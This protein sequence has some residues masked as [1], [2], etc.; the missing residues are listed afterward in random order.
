MDKYA[1]RSL[2]RITYKQVLE[3]MPRI[4]R[5]WKITTADHY[6]PFDTPGKRSKRQNADYY[7]G[8]YSQAGHNRRCFTHVEAMPA[9]QYRN[10]L[11]G[12]D[13]CIGYGCSYCMWLPTEMTMWAGL[14]GSFEELAALGSCCLLTP[15]FEP[16][17]PANLIQIV[18]SP[19]DIYNRS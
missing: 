17:W 16:S 15:P 14:A 19:L 5:A 9:S 13:G 4:V 18:L 10:L 6:L 8:S 12:N 1:Q 2:H 7:P 11:K 3:K